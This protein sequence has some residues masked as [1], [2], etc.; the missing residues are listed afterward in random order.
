[1]GIFACSVYFLLSVFLLKA[2][3][4][5][6]RYIITVGAVTALFASLL[7]SILPQVCAIKD[8]FHGR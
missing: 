3:I 5:I 8:I 4:F 2:S 1:M 6:L 7:G